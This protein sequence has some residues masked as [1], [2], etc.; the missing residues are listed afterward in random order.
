MSEE[1]YSSKDGPNLLELRL[2]Y[3]AFMGLFTKRSKPHYSTCRSFNMKDSGFV[4]L[5]YFAN[6]TLVQKCA[7][8]A[9]NPL[10]F[11]TRVFFQRSI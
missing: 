4:V 8:F 7:K 11:Q 10:G 9:Y 3:M 6:C 2:G 1:I 5:F